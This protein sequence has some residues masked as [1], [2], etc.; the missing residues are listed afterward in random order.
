[1]TKRNDFP[2]ERRRHPRTLLA[3]TLGC[4]RLEPDGGDVVDSL[5]MRDISRGGL[6]AYSTQPYYPG[7]RIVLSLPLPAGGDRRNV[8]AT[9]VR[10]RQADEGYSIGFAFDAPYVGE[11]FQYSRTTVAATKQAVAA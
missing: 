5:H 2:V 7:Q 11:S 9:I 1:M 4:I 10:C 3:M 8:Y 6:G